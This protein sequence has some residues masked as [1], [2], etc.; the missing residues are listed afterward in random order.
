MNA[1]LDDPRVVPPG[2]GEETLREYGRQLALD[3]LLELA[4]GTSGMAGAAQGDASPSPKASPIGARW[5]KRVVWMAGL[6]AALLLMVGLWRAL[7]PGPLPSPPE[8]AKQNSRAA[9]LSQP[10]IE[11]DLV[12]LDRGD[13]AR[14][15][16]AAGWRIEPTGNAEYR[17]EKP[18]RIRLQRGELLVEEFPSPFARGRG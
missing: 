2:D 9:D 15:T 7:R 12:T 10:P 17:I 8:V 16:L 1:P 3:S 18:D 13:A 4:L 6:A 14:P 5:R 11:R